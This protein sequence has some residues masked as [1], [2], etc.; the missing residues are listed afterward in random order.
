[1]KR[2]LNGAILQMDGRTVGHVVTGH[3]ENDA[4]K[5]PTDS[6]SFDTKLVPLYPGFLP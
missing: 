2:A 5:P 3:Q 4:R 1:M 6:G